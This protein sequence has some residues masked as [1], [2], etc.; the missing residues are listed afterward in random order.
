MGPVPPPPCAAPGTAPGAARRDRSARIHPRPQRPGVR[1]VRRSRGRPPRLSQCRAVCRICGSVVCCPQAARRGPRGF[2]APVGAK[3]RAALGVRR[4]RGTHAGMRARCWPS[5]SSGANPTGLRFGRSAVG[6]AAFAPARQLTPPA[7]EGCGALGPSRACCRPSRP[8]RPARGLEGG[9]PPDA[10]P[11]PRAWTP[12]LSGR[13]V[14]GG[15]PVGHGSGAAAS[16]RCAVG[17]AARDQGRR[18]GP[19]PS[20]PGP[21]PPAAV[22]ADAPAVGA[23]PGSVRALSPAA[24]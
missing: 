8:R 9:P 18:V 1:M 12:P 14:G 10:P 3:S 20:L 17:R 13:S 23:G 15:K 11:S 2:V 5:P 7:R 24:S 6:G 19:S 4:E 22:R 16:E 21:T